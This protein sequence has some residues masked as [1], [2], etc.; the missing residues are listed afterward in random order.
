MKTTFATL[1]HAAPKM[2]CEELMKVRKT[3]CSILDSE[4]VK[5]CDSNYAL[6]NPVIAENIDIKKI[7]DGCVILRLVQLAKEK[8]VDY[9]PS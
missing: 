4:F 3:L 2:D 1:I 8:N 7:D 5:E 6:I 9:I